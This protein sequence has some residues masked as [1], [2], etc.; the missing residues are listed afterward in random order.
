MGSIRQFAEDWTLDMMLYHTRKALTFAQQNDLPVMYVTEDTIRSNPEHLKVLLTTAIES[1]AKRVCLC[2]TVGAG[3]PEGVFNLV[4]WVQELI[5]DLDTEVG[6]DW[7]GHRDRDLAI[8]N[9]L[10]AVRAGAAQPDGQ[11][12]RAVDYRHPRYPPAARGAGRPR[13]NSRRFSQRRA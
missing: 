4:T 11:C 7:H 8:A 1:G 12:P 10:A 9:C 3:V 5:A 6:I 13:G 2:D